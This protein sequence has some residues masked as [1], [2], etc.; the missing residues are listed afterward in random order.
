M[1]NYI[2]AFKN[3]DLG[4]FKKIHDA[5]YK[6]IYLLCFRIL[7]NNN[8]D[9]LDATQEVF[10]Q[11][12]KSINSLNDIDKFNAWI[13][14]IAISKC[15]YIIKKNKDII[16][17]DDQFS[18][19]EDEREDIEVIVCND[20]KK[21]L[22]LEAINTL[23]IK[24]RMVILLYYY[25][26]LKIDEISIA[27]EIPI[28]TVK[29]RLNSAKKDLKNYLSK[30]NKKDSLYGSSLP[31]LLLLKYN[32]NLKI[33]SKYYLKYI[34]NKIN[35]YIK[36]INPVKML[37]NM[38]LFQN[39]CIIIGLGLVTIP[40]VYNNIVSEGLNSKKNTLE[41]NIDINQTTYPANEEDLKKPQIIGAN[42]KTIKI[43]ESFDIKKDVYIKV[44]N[45]K[46]AK[47]YAYGYVDINKKGVY[48]I[49]YFAVDSEKNTTIIER[50]IT[51]IN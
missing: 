44:G 46:T 23:A 20:E 17:T 42:D 29:S 39:I 10:I 33:N 6:K 27:L 2:L 14:K 34:L 16:T 40:A 8:E 22:I 24:K 5:Y 32:D 9:A 3:G 43:G 47:G 49:Y 18:N 41:Y 35:S 21:K 48:K 50:S 1:K 38:S 12:Y 11:V 13:N 31:L 7:N 45:N 28:G 15:S 30:N 36:I 51:V 25:S 4:A 26:E 19:I 37:I